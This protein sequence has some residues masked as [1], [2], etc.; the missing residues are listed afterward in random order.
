MHHSC[1]NNI[2]GKTLCPYNRTLTSGGSSGGEAALIAM[3]GSCV[4][5]GTDIGGSVRGPAA[6]CGIYS[7]RQSA[8]RLPM[9]GM[10][11]AMVG[12][13]SILAILGPM[14]SSQ[15]DIQMFMEHALST[16]P[17]KRDQSLVAIPW[18]TPTLPKKIRV[19]IMWHDGVVYP[20]PPITRGLK[21]VK[22]AMEKYPDLFEVTDWEG[23]DSKLAWDIV[24]SLYFMDGGAQDLAAMAASG[25]PHDPL[26]DFIM[27]QKGVK[28]NT[29]TEA[30]EVQ[31][32]R[33]CS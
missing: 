2:T 18:R 29:I 16:E 3:R 19:G 21:E 11:M 10:S 22:A 14:C 33:G 28:D 9:S 17:W 26:T 13:E 32:F 24:S 30:W 23:L 15:R 7:L 31:P 4:G 20:H 1:N 12:A 6:N 5:L 8:L 27:S 25:E